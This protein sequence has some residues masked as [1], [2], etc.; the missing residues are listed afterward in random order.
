M[1]QLSV[2]TIKISTIK[3]FDLLF[4]LLS[5]FLLFSLPLF[6]HWMNHSVIQWSFIY[7]IWIDYLPL[8]FIFVINRLVLIKQLLFKSKSILYILSV[9]VLIAITVFSTRQITAQ[10][11]SADQ[12]H[13]M[14]R[15]SKPNKTDRVARFNNR[16]PSKAAYPPYVNL[17]LVSFLLV[18]FDTGT[19]MS[20][21]WAKTQEQKAELEKENIKNELAFLR[22]QISPHFLM[23]TLNNIHS[24]VDF[25]T[26]EAKSAIAKLSVLMRHLLYESDV[27]PTSLTKEINF[28]Q[29]YIQLMQLRFSE[30]VEVRLELPKQFP[31]ISI[32]PLLFTNI[33]ENAFKYGI[34]YNHKSFVHIKIQV[35]KNALQFSISNSIHKEPTNFESTGIGIKNTKKRLDLLYNKSYSFAYSNSGNVFNAS[36]KIPI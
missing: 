11:R 21:K 29:S 34:S 9:I 28:I 30:E 14:L 18:G 5:W 13:G 22:N 1:E 35:L 17:I 3:R 8:L 23:N 2:N 20:V 12:G 6:F 7:D 19:K 24:L 4:V 33:L 27:E 31:K 10:N 16:K 26:K 15:F 36:I 32:P 25:D